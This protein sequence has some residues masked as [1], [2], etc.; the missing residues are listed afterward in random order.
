MQ[1]V[2]F[3]NYHDVYAIEVDQVVSIE[4]LYPITKIPLSPDYILGIINLRGEI[5]PV[6]DFNTMID[7]RI[8]KDDDINKKIIIVKDAE[9]QIG[10]L[11]KNDVE[12]INVE[13]NLLRDPLENL[14]DKDKKFIK[15]SF[16]YKDGVANI[17][18]IRYIVTPEKAV[19]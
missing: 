10:L 2:I 8:S 15:G 3:N 12:I 17:L 6:I 18:N 16:I 1:F 14:T 7:G 11:I 4:K 13:E 5:I 19:L 9:N